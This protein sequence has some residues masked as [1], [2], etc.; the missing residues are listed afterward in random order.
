MWAIVCNFS[1]KFNF[2]FYSSVYP[3]IPFHNLNRP[4]NSNFFQNKCFK[5]PFINKKVG[6]LKRGPRKVIEKRGGTFSP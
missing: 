6:G 2:F 5:N 4:K 1:Q 3:E